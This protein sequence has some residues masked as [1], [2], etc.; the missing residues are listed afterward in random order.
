MRSSNH[1]LIIQRGET[2]SLDF[3]LENKD[4]SPY[5]VGND[6]IN[7][8][9][10]IT[11]SSSLYNQNG[12]VSLRYW[13]PVDLTFDYTQ[14]IKLSDIKKEQYG[15]EEAYWDMPDGLSE[16]LPT[17]YFNNVYVT[18]EEGDC[19]FESNGKFWYYKN[20]L[21]EYNSHLVINFPGKDTEKL[22]EQNYVYNIRLVGGSN[23]N[24][25]KPDVNDIDNSIP[26]LPS[27]KLS[28]LSNLTGGV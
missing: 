12:R 11:I 7:P 19:V 5:I 27:T 16:G 13:I 3:V 23:L 26:I 1:E 20:G 25:K 28:V 9:Y 14:V 6:L 2:V 17:G 18:F 24:S 4:G 10:L 21:K 8:H 15:Y 22:S